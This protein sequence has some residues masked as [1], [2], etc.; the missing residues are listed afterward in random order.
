MEWAALLRA[1]LGRLGLTPEAFWRLS[2]IELRLMLGAEAVT[3]PLDRRRL[4]ELAAQFPD[5]GENGDRR[6]L[7]PERSS[8]GF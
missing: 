4:A 6:Y 7:R 2:P 5:G 3:A 8:G 1:G